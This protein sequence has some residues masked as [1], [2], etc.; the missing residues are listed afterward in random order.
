MFATILLSCVFIQDSLTIRNACPPKWDNPF[1]LVETFI[2]SPYVRYSK[3]YLELPGTR[4]VIDDTVVIEETS[5]PLN[6]PDGTYKW[7]PV[8][9]TDIIGQRIDIETWSNKQDP[10]VIDFEFVV[11]IKNWNESPWTY[12]TLSLTMR[13]FL[14]P[15]PNAEIRGNI[16][17]NWTSGAEWYEQNAVSEEEIEYYQINGLFDSFQRRWQQAVDIERI[18]VNK[19]TTITRTPSGGD[20]FFNCRQV[21]APIYDGN[22]NL[23]GSKER[24]P[25]IDPTIEW[26]G[27]LWKAMFPQQENAVIALGE[28]PSDIEDEQNSGFGMHLNFSLG[29]AIPM[30]LNTEGEKIPPLEVE[31][32]PNVLVLHGHARFEMINPIYPAEGCPPRETIP[33]DEEPDYS[34]DV[35]IL[36]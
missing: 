4:R 15:L 35:I 10:T 11:T 3:Y 27:E 25:L 22:L 7:N 31:W 1:V 6:P 21:V 32:L 5:D 36:E 24:P 26:N 30:M 28:V 33:M 12:K 23:V 2:P 18:V 16:F 19:K 34:T 9:Y 20:L 8:Y 13:D 29:G 17:W 14:C